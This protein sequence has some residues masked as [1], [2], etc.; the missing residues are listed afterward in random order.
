[1]IDIPLTD[2]LEHFLSGTWTGA[3]RIQGLQGGARAYVLALVAARARRPILVVAASARDAE[4]LFDDL[5]FFLSEDRGLAPLG[6]RLHLFPSWEVLPFENLSPHPDNI[7]GRL[8]GLY[9]LVE[10]STPILIATPAALMQRVIPKEAL[11]QSYLYLVAGQDVSRES[12]LEHLVQW[13]YQNVPLVEERGDFSARGGIV[14]LFSPGYRRPLRLEFDGD[15]L[16]SMREFNP[17]T[18]RTEQLQDEMLILPMKEFSLKRAGLEEALRRLDQRAVELEV[19]R[20]E[21]NSL[22]ES[23]RAGIPFPGIEF[24]APY[25]FSQLVPVFSYLPA[26][27]LIWLDGADRI[28]AEAGRFSQLAW[29]RNERSKED[30]R[31][32]ARV[33]AEYL[34]EHE[35]RE[36]LHVFPQV[37]CESLVIMAASERAREM[38]LTAETYLT[39]DARQE[40]ALHGKEASLKP[41]VEQFKTWETEKII[42]VAPTKGDA[43]R[44]RELLSNYDIQFTLTEEPAPAALGR[45][46]FT[47]GIVCGHLTQGFRLPEAHLVLITFDE[48]FGTRKRQPTTSTKN[49]PSHFLTS[50]SELKQDDYVVHLDHGIGVYRGLR[51][52]KVADVEGEFLH[53]E[54]EAGDRLYLPVD[55]INMVQ[56]YIGGDGAQPSLD[57]LGGTAWEKVKAKARKSI[58]AM[59][60]ELVQLYAVR[61]ARAGT[62]FA[63]PDAMYKEF[64]AAFEYEETPDQQRAIDET[65]AGMHSKKPMDRLICGDV[66]FGKTE[67]AMRAAFL[68]VEGGKQVALL[69]PT[70]I[71]AQQHL[72]TFRHRFRNHPVRVE[73]V[74]RFLTAKEVTH[75]LQDTAKGNVDIIIGTHRLLQKDVEFRDLGLVIIDEEHRFGVVHK[76][77]F[78]KLRQLVD[79]LSLTA[80][81]IPRTLHMSLVGIRDLSIIETP[82]VDRLAIQTYVTRYNENLIRDAVLRELERGGQVFFLHNRVETIDR[83]AQ[84]LADLVPEAKMAMAH[85]QMR[86]KELEKV[87]LDFFENKTQVLVCSAIIESGLDFPN[88][89]TIIINR[90]DKFGLAQL[91]QLRG[92]VGRSHR[93]AYAYLLIPG[94]QAI[95]PDAGKRLRA[96]QEI[97]GL[98]GGFKLALH[99]LEI[100]GAGNLLGE[101]Q[102]GQI[103]AVGFELYTEMMEKA[104]KELKGEEVAPEVEPEIRLGIPAYF[105]ETYIPDVNQRLYFYKRLASLRSPVDL[106]ELKGEIKDRFGPYISVVDN[107]FLLMNL[108]RVLKEFLVQQISAS[109]GRV[110]LLFHPESPVKVEKL[111]ELIHKQKN[112]FRLAPDGRLSFSPKHRQWPAVMDE[113]AE[114]LHSIGETAVQQ[115]DFFEPAHG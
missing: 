29:D 93:H 10:D 114:L 19:D 16:E 53:L 18:Q 74:S 109:D 80:T 41:L 72:Q 81:P 33:E 52:L 58:F 11:K 111:L 39:T 92:R 54:Y 64:E 7:A 45:A 5:A 47:R 59:A 62:A 43:A 9:K 104:V 97:D 70:T 60:E 51:F 105:P 61:E 31:L 110:F 21:K 4:N 85:G 63:P 13:G 57:R 35:W 20:R 17:A 48:I 103:T 8:E 115:K 98:G 34:N 89:N 86:P 82:P 68:A 42:F 26:E 23:M 50:L 91:Y 36:A 77:R 24:L 38:T 40:T 65:L 106:E 101:Q 32:V 84:R 55:R 90:A 27:T 108:R 88:A 96:L 94:E 112:R 87:M 99:D 73:M 113:V 28:E 22:L 79:V 102:S 71:L 100:R 56:K 12:I 75:V 44:L 25:F 30:H 3:K 67:V 14:D 37:H 46:E 78:K 66:G 6:K 15:R 49:Y 76:E 69:A 107:L 1:M 2:R 83:L 95:T